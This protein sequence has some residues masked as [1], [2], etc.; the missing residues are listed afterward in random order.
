MSDDPMGAFF[1]QSIADGTTFVANLADGAA[2]VTDGYGGWDAVSRPR[3][4]AVTEWKGRNH[5]VVEIPFMLDFWMLE[6]E[7]DTGPGEECELRV[8]RLEKLAGLYSTVQPPVCIVQG[9]GA[10]PHDYKQRPSLHWVVDNISWDKAV[11]LRRGTNGRR[12]RCGGTVTVRQ[13]LVARDIFYKI[14]K[15]QKA[16][17]PRDYKV[18]KGDTLVS[19]ARHF[20]HDPSL[21]KIIADANRMRDRRKLNIGTWIKVPRI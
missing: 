9:Y 7:G 2:V 14:K 17:K 8:K 16:V 3:D 6:W 10:I 5:L 18:K 20:Y 21:W 1:I 15:N 12:M 11:E 4:V 13:Y 19:I